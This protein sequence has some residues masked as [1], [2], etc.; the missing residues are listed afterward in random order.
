MDAA[1]P[2]T[3][4]SADVA[5]SVDAAVDRPGDISVGEAD[6]SVQ[7]SDTTDGSAVTLSTG[8]ADDTA[9]ETAVTEAAITET[10]VSSVKTAEHI[11]SHKSSAQNTAVG[12]GR[13][14]L[15][16]KFMGGRKRGKDGK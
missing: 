9:K 5:E 1:D 11:S 15:F 3:D 13:K 2:A 12:T 8:A 16:Q 7:A 6:N 4:S 10:S 14:G